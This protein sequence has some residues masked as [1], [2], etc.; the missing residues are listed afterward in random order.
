MNSHGPHT[1]RCR[2]DGRGIVP[3]P[4]GVAIPCPC[5]GCLPGQLDHPDRRKNQFRDA[6]TWTPEYRA[7]VFAALEKKVLA[8]LQQAQA[9]YPAVADLP[10][11]N[12]RQMASMLGL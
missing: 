4:S 6:T 11:E 12:Q 2:C 7:G 5:S 8:T 10:E 1:S 3:G 9:I